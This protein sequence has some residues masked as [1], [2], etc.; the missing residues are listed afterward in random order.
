V[1]T[2]RE[3]LVAL[4]TPSFQ[5]VAQAVQPAELADYRTAYFAGVQVALLAGGVAG[6][7][8]A[9]VAWVTLG[10]RDVLQTVYEHRD[11]RGTVPAG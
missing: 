4:G 3:V 10:R 5:S 8:G 9:V 7:V 6:V 2:F 1:A 11:E